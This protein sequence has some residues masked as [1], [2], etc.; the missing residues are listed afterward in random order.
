MLPPLLLIRLHWDNI[1]RVSRGSGTVAGT[2]ALLWPLGQAVIMS[3]HFNKMA[4]HAE[5]TNFE[6]VVNFEPGSIFRTFRQRVPF[7]YFLRIT[8]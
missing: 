7:F 3:H 6:R 5:Q 8:A 1:E 4:A 2:V